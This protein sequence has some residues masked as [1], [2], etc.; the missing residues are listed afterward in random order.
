M[1]KMAKATKKSKPSS[2]DAAFDEFLNKSGSLVSAIFSEYDHDDAVNRSENLGRLL[3]QKILDTKGIAG[4]G[5]PAAKFKVSMVEGLMHSSLE[6]ATKIEAIR[7]VVIG[8]RKF[9]ANHVNHGTLT[10]EEAAKADHVVASELGN[11]NLKSYAEAWMDAVKEHVSSDEFIQ[12]VEAIKKNLPKNTAGRLE[13]LAGND[14]STYLRK[15]SLNIQGGPA[16]P[17]GPSM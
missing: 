1:S 11:S 4:F 10:L 6:R 12:K 7:A 9:L 2:D 3:A 15:F 16:K 13:D 8:V 17:K 14:A 5:E